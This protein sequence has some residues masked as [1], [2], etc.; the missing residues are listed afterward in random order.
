MADHTSKAEHLNDYAY[1]CTGSS[2]EA[3]CSDHMEAASQARQAEWADA[4]RGRTAITCPARMIGSKAEAA[5][6]THLRGRQ[7]WRTATHSGHG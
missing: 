3:R 2:F 1:E 6:E 7:S 4:Q 5:R